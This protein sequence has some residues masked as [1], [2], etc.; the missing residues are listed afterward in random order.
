MLTVTD[1][2]L[3]LVVLENGWSARCL[4]RKLG[5]SYAHQEIAAHA[6]ES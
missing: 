5:L 1:K 6:Y 3:A 4:A 2:Q